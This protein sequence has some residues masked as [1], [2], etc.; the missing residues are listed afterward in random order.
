LTDIEKLPGHIKSLSLGDWNKL[1]SLL[2]EI[3]HTKEFGKVKGGEELNDGSIKMLYWES[4][5]IVD[6][7]FHAVHELGIVPVFDW[8]NW[9]E[10]KAIIHNPKQDFNSL[11]IVALCKLF[12][13]I[14][15]TDRFNDGFLVSAFQN[16][17]LPKII[18]ALKDKI[19]LNSQI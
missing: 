7:F 19:N 13:L 18:C 2:S 12:T 17:T 1:F 14:I 5:E 4:S 15:R 9:K 10:G 3:E 6:K 11:D 8:A 16:G